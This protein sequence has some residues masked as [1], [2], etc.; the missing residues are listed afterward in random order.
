MWLLGGR[1]SEFRVGEGGGYIVTDKN[2]FWI[3]LAPYFFPLYAA[4]LVGAWALAGWI[5][6]AAWEHRRWLFAGLGVTWGFHG[7]FSVWMIVKGQSDLTS[8]GT[9]FS[10]VVIYL[11]NLALLAAL[12]VAACPDVTWTDF[13]QRLLHDAWRFSAPV[14]NQ[15]ADWFGG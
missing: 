15:L 10:L 4:I 13:G 7:T 9:F 2:N 8:Q 5:E 6:P 1:V 12:L 11:I 14:V 3:A